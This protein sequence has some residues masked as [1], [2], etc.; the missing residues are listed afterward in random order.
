MENLSLSDS[1]IDALNR[2]KV[3]AMEC[4]LNNAHK[5]IYHDIRY[6]QRLANNVATIA[7]ELQITSESKR[8]LTMCGW[9]YTSTFTSLPTTSKVKEKRQAEGLE[10]I[11]NTLVG[12]LT[13]LGVKPEVVEEITGILKQ[14]IRPAESQSTLS[15]ILMDAIMMDLSDSESLNHVKKLYEEAVLSDVNLSLGKFYDL[16]TQYF[17]EY[18]GHSKYGREKIAPSILLLLE[19]VEREK[20]KLTRKKSILLKKE[21]EISEEELKELRKNLNSVK[22]R[23]VRG[24]QTLFRTTSRNHYTLNEMVDRKANIMITVNAIILSVVIGG[25]LG[26]S[27]TDSIFAVLPLVILSLSSLFSII[28]A[29]LSIT[30]NRTQGQ[31][32]KEEILNKEGNLLY[33]GNFHNM[34]FRDYEWGML[35]KLNDSNFLYSSMIKDLYYLGKS[36]HRKYS[37]IRISLQFFVIGL[38]SSFI[39]FML[40]RMV[41]FI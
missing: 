12:E 34:K 26:R 25:F 16:C 27:A 30:P 19:K 31:F 11:D 32:T 41:V 15:G 7:D 9:L 6:G 3:Y 4:I 8:V 24:V 23:D 13:R 28:F 20:R 17:S 10:Y 2:V 18:N 14:L 21:L 39:I 22:G 35:E 33:F 29:V 38:V 5:A 1:K 40:G 36:L 37:F